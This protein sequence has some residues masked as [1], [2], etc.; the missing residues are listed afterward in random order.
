MKK[1]FFSLML[2]L[3]MLFSLLPVITDTAVAAGGT[4]YPY[5]VI[6]KGATETSYY[7]VN[8]QAGS[9]DSFAAFKTGADAEGGTSYSTVDKAMTAITTEVASGSATLQFA[10]TGTTAASATGTLS[11]ES[12]VD[13]TGGGTYILLGSLEGSANNTV[14]ADSANI[15]AGSGVTITNTNGGS[16]SSSPL[17][18]TAGGTITVNEGANISGNS[19]T[20]C[21]IYN[22][23][24]GSVTVSGGT[25]TAT[26]G[27]TIWSTGSGEIVISGGT[28][29]CGAEG[30]C[31]AVRN[32]GSGDITISAGKVESIYTAA[33]FNGSGGDITISGGEVKADSGFALFNLN[34][35]ITVSGGKVTGNL[36]ATIYN[37]CNGYI[38][39]KG[40]T[41]D[42]Q[43]N[44]AIYNSGD[45]IVAVSDGEVKSEG[46]GP[47]TIYN[48]GAGSVTVSGGGK[49]IAGGASTD[50]IYN[51]GNGS[52]TVSG[53]EVTGSRAAIYNELS[54][55]ITVSGGTLET[56]SADSPAIFNHINGKV[57][58]S[59]TAKIVSAS[60]YGSIEL[61]GI[62][63]GDEQPILE[64]SGGT[65]TNSDNYGIWNCGTCAIKISGGMVT[66]GRSDIYIANQ[67]TLIANDGA[68]TPAYY[69]GDPISV[70]FGGV[71]ESGTTVA[72][73][74]VS[75]GVNDDLFSITNSGHY[76]VMNEHDGNLVINAV[77][78]NWLDNTDP[79][80]YSTDWYDANPSATSFTV[81][82][83]ADLAGLAYLVN[84]G[85]D[86]FSGD[87]ITLVNSINICAH[88]WVPISNVT[89]Q[90]SG[91][92][93][94]N[95]KTVSGLYIDESGADYQGLFSYIDGGTVENLTVT[96]S[97]TSKRGVGCIAGYA[98]GAVIK[99]CVSSGT[100]HGSGRYVGGIAG[101]VYNATVDSCINTG[102]VSSNSDYVGGIVGL[103]QVAEVINCS[104]SGAVSITGLY[105]G[106]IA[107][108]NEG[109]IANCYNR[110]SVSGSYGGGITGYNYG[111]TENCYNWGTV[112]GSK[113]G[114]V[115]GYNYFSG[116]V[117][118][119]YWLSG[120]AAACLGSSDSGA[121][122]S[123]SGI[124]SISGTIMAGTAA[125]CGSDQ[126]LAY[127]SSLLTALNKWVIM[128]NGVDYLEWAAD[129]GNVNGGYPVFGALHIQRLITGQ[130]SADNAYTV[131]ATQVTGVGKTYQWNKFTAA[132]AEASLD[133]ANNAY[134]T[135]LTDLLPNGFGLTDDIYT[136]GH[137]AWTFADGVYASGAK[138]IDSGYSAMSIPVTIAEGEGISF[139]WKVSSEAACDF[140]SV[141]LLTYSGGQYALASGTSVESISGEADW[142]SKLYSGLPAGTYY[143]VFAYTK[144]SGAYTG[145]DCGYVRLAGVSETLTGNTSATLSRTGLSGGEM[146]R[147]KVT[148][149]DGVMLTSDNIT[150][151][152]I[153]S[154]NVT[155]SLTGVTTDNSATSAVLNSSYTAVLTPT[156][157]GYSMSVTVTMSGT[158]ITSSAYNSSTKTVGIADVIGDIVIT[159]TA[160]APSDNG[161][162][163]STPTR[164]IAVTETS[165]DL[166]SG[167]GN[168]IKAAANMN[169]AFS[170][171]V[172]VKVTDSEQNDSGF[173]LSAGNEVYPFDISL[174]V[175]GTNTKTEPKDGYAVTI[176]LPV[177]EK[178][179]DV[180]E[181]IS[182]LHK[183][184]DGTVT[185]LKSQL[186]QINGAWYLVFEA[187]EFSPYALVVSDKGTYDETEGLPYYVDSDGNEVFIGFTANGKYIAPSGVTV[188]FKKN[189]KTFT[190]TGSHWAKNYI[191]F[192]TGREL[193]TGM[194]DNIF[195]PDAGM[196]R[197]MF[198]TVI[199]RL[200]ERSYC[201]IT[202]GA[203]HAFT[204]VDYDSWYG[205]YIDWA[206]QNGIITGSGGGKYWPDR[207]INREEMAA[208]LYRFAEFLGAVS[209]GNAEK[210]AYA[211]AADISAWA[212][213]AA[214][215]CQSTGVITGRENGN[216]IPAGYGHQ[217]GSRGNFGTVY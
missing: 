125:N 19:S 170:D 215:Y 99:N 172:E 200:Y 188:L 175:K 178:L 24:S 186:K 199:G 55:T 68:E 81:S 182:I 187:T 15:I 193:F 73:S 144:D 12:M 86:T 29:T 31:F 89:Y 54:G 95:G 135:A 67:G 146:F 189:T 168:Q 176:S 118:S 185:T 127:G 112:T 131:T 209:T 57:T 75:S 110:G 16:L 174:Y 6:T 126:T 142:T 35:N 60:Q 155:N 101:Y 120:S 17:N 87:K 114:G 208:I 52:V 156:N 117:K 141:G 82:T 138:E 163:S 157:S 119:C 183:S 164:T 79:H 217:S 46:A 204:D 30:D 100:V 85:T 11:L 154:Y 211:D 130:P 109:A 47:Y 179:L 177:P 33:V 107:G 42:S 167:S 113:S 162:S 158:D 77:S 121:I 165:S 111:G 147:C 160:S 103:S 64:V 194:G 166:F 5:Y 108:R 38:T 213:D 43:D 20:G 59:G 23:G 190:D 45:G 104:N 102:E 27:D 203:S 192:V 151:E 98:E 26:A 205:P 62:G 71:I 78:G 91:T 180:K 48:N 21:A 40:G 122:L 9:A 123:G 22:N 148:Y 37:Y 140:L 214:L 106:G 94:G 2:I 196:T 152:S 1:R 93:D 66:G 90:F 133:L 202:A 137:S 132:D 92:F 149:D 197:A 25:V 97:V 134:G 159:A 116:Q 216:F 128:T 7:Y 61:W 74:G 105:A 150:L 32:E 210:S 8:K 80:Y 3:G 76:L 198:A 58:I 49:V 88:E 96:G 212:A 115:A 84:N 53:G 14:C 13:L 50:A 181:Q 139:E 44:A 191:D 136:G 63:T 28:V 69:S 169:N 161:G 124:F 143:L 10:L 65:I 173:G 34:G 83:A 201:Q 72:V 70:Y 145:S 36:A 129:S 184:D 56:T 51:G 153:T 18:A 4:V 41:V 195:D 171:S 39:V 207:S 206:A